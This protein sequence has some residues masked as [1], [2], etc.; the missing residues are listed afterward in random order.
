MYNM[1][2][3]P[4]LRV[5]ISSTFKDL[6][7]ERSLLMTRVFPRLIQLASL[8]GVNL[9]PV[10]LRWG[11]TDNEEESFSS[12]TKIID[13]C[14]KEID[15]A[16]C[17]IGIIGDRYGW[18]P[19]SHD[20]SKSNMLKGDYAWLV[21]AGMS[22][23]EI[24][25]QYGVLNRQKH[26]YNSF[27]IKK[28]DRVDGTHNP[29]KGLRDKVIQNKGKEC[30]VYEFSSL[31]QLA[32]YV[33]I[34]VLKA[35]DSLFPE[36]EMK[37]HK[38]M[39]Y[40]Q[41]YIIGRYNRSYIS[42]DKLLGELDTGLASNQ[43]AYITGLSGVGKSAML[44]NWIA[45]HVGDDSLHIFYYF[46]SGN[47]DY[48]KALIFL[49]YEI[50][51]TYNL[52]ISAEQIESPY[53]LLQ[54]LLKSLNQE[55]SIVLAIDDVNED[56]ISFRRWFQLPTNVKL[57]F[58]CDL[59]DN[60]GVWAEDMGYPSVVIDKM[61]EK[62]RRAFIELYL[63][64]NRKVLEKERTE[65]FARVFTGDIIALR[66]LLDILIIFGKYET[67][68]N[69]IDD[70]TF[71]NEECYDSDEYHKM[72]FV[73]DKF[74]ERKFSEETRFY[75][76]LLNLYETSFPEMPVKEILAT[77]HF[78]TLRESEI[79]DLVNI[80]PLSWASVKA[81]WESFLSQKDGYVI[82]N[83]ENLSSA[84]V[85]RYKNLQM[86][87]YE[88]AINFF[89]KIGSPRKHI[90]R[91]QYYSN[92]KDYK[93][94]STSLCDIALFKSMNSNN[95]EKIAYYWNEAL[96]NLPGENILKNYAQQLISNK[97]ISEDYLS[98]LCDFSR[99]CIDWLWNGEVARLVADKAYSEC[100]KRKGVA[101]ELS[102]YAAQNAAMSH[103][104]IGDYSGAVD[105]LD[106]TILYE[107]TAN[108][109]KRGLYECYM[110]KGLALALLHHY[111]DSHLSLFIARKI[112]LE[113]DGERSWMMARCLLY[114]GISYLLNHDK[115]A[116]I[117]LEKAQSIISD[118]FG[119]HNLLYA[120]IS[121]A[122]A[123]YFYQ[124]G[125]CEEAF[126]GWTHADVGYYM[127]HDNNIRFAVSHII[128][129][130]ILRRAKQYE[131]AKDYFESANNILNNNEISVET[132][133]V[134]K[135]IMD[136]L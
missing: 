121:L 45:R 51:D 116:I 100:K 13:V 115:Q 14:L 3:I 67:I 12:N 55:T 17:F 107:S 30:M 42:N 6:D 21:N 29:L 33:E 19:S 35:L 44:A 34:S 77:I 25:M 49:C 74:E 78:T 69:F 39:H 46:P 47:N 26:S 15:A 71:S 133:K 54:S 81:L 11:I 50:A 60:N 24:E 22:M 109:N 82:I 131:D 92:K 23:T 38:R 135:G 5:F 52:S 1:S 99:F 75:N 106:K 10:D 129:G 125:K 110:K 37:E 4:E 126:L 58:T 64:L 112:I 76:A 28:S 97:I 89:E 57:L 122:A 98:L 113:T 61:S 7:E 20:L 32:H 93:S 53:T 127:L 86:V 73:N 68:K 95:R 65:Y 63:R 80:T 43:C 108:N 128:A 94:L 101:N 62:D 111:N 103:I 36:K 136:N 16:Q 70:F 8:R 2:I 40:S 114:E 117:S 96:S 66:I 102:L 118:E 83:N 134:I 119:T 56:W 84:I 120:D 48:Q 130:K 18:C 124:G 87:V 85:K 9:V 88:R 41:K 105:I 31:Q 104:L 91:L 27:F 123:T 132:Q 59:F 90:T 79:A 72:D